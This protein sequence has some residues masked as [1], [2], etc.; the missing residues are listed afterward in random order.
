MSRTGGVLERAYITRAS[1]PDCTD[2]TDYSALVNFGIGIESTRR[3][4][5]HG[6]YLKL[7]SGK[8]AND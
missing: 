2:L 7:M 3:L 8:L 5:P 1:L 6:P 4:Y